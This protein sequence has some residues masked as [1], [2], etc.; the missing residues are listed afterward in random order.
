MEPRHILVVDDDRDFA[1]SIADLLQYRG[2]SVDTAFSG[3]DAV[4]KFRSRNF[5]MALIDVK[6]PGIDGVESLA[7]IRKLKPSARVVMMTGYAVPDLLNRAME[8]GAWGVMHKP[9]E[10]DEVLEL[11]GRIRTT[12]AV[13]V[14]DDDADFVASLKDTLFQEGF[15][16]ASAY[17]GQSALDII[18]SNP[19][20]VLLLD[21]RMPAMNGLE[22]FLA[23]H[24]EGLSVPTVVVTGYAQ[25]ESESIDRMKSMSVRGVLSKPVEPRQLI[26]LLDTLRLEA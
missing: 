9:L 11:I 1:E 4:E 14:V 24:S 12:G 10:V 15:N 22:T 3:E 26:E 8:Y 13:L 18:R 17:D 25:E 5:D 16:V 2:H 21:L 6:M 23:L 20:D 7:A 19:P